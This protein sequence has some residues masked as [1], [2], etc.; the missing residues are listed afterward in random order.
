VRLRRVREFRAAS[1]NRAEERAAALLADCT[2]AY[3]S[4]GGPFPLESSWP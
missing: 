3:A 2:G 1:P 4:S